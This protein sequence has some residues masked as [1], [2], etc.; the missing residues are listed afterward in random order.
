MV[1]REEGGRER[2]VHV[3]GE[4]T[5]ILGFHVFDPLPPHCGGVEKKGARLW[6]PKKKKKA[7]RRSRSLR[8]KSPGFPWSAPDGLNSPKSNLLERKGM[9]W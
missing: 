1:T 8:G 6:T 5:G 9:R 3:F 4:K 2:P 7:R